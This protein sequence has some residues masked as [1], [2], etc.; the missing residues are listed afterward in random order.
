MALRDAIFSV[1]ILVF[2]G[3]NLYISLTMKSDQRGAHPQKHKSN[4]LLMLPVAHLA[5]LI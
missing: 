5:W 2:F 4:I 1:K 3:V